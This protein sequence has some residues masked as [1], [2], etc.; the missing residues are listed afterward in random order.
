VRRAPGSRPGGAPRALSSPACRGGAGVLSGA[1]PDR[2]AAARPCAAQARCAAH[3]P[4]REGRGGVPRT[5]RVSRTAAGRL[6]HRREGVPPAGC[7]GQ[8]RRSGRTRGLVV[9]ALRACGAVGVLAARRTS[10][11]WRYRRHVT[12]T[13]HPGNPAIAGP[14]EGNAR[15]GP[16]IPGRR[17]S[18]T[19]LQGVN[20]RDRRLAQRS[21]SI[22]HTT[23]GARREHQQTRR[24]VRFRA[25][26]RR[27]SGGPLADH[28]H[29]QPARLFEGRGH[30]S[31]PAPPTT[32]RIGAPR[33]A[34][35]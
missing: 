2:H 28:R 17:T 9:V 19:A 1:G 14:R 16:A 4:T 29:G 3:R 13:N 15:A 23:D 33:T 8:D 10:L 35:G 6:D 5:P 32:S 18:I 21:S 31:S 34:R 25:R 30:P 12:R 26:P 27:H 22:R 7:A 24:P 20:F 11:R